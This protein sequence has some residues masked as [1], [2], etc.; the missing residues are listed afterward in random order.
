[1]RPYRADAA[2][3]ALFRECAA[4]HPGRVALEQGGERWTYAE[5]DQWSD[6]AAGALR[7]AG[8]EA[9][10]V[11]G[12]AGERSPRLLAAFLA[13][14]KAGAAYLPLDP[15]YPAARLSA[16]TADAAPALMIVA[17]GLDAGWLG[18]YAGPVLSLADCEAGDARPVSSA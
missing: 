14:L 16:M 5:L 17:D 10:A 15:T 11:V 13:A 4:A 1:E 12:V 18:D 9:G 6:R 3:D 7:A 2:I 8:V